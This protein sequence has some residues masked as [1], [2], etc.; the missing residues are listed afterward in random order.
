M[1]SNY[2]LGSILALLFSD[3]LKDLS[4]GTGIRRLDIA[5]EVIL[6]NGLKTQA[7]R[8]DEA[9]KNME[10]IKKSRNALFRFAAN[11]KKKD[12]RKDER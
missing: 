10:T 1:A 4:E 11:L 3:V 8:S 2:Y 7:M 9:R 6:T 5:K 12:P